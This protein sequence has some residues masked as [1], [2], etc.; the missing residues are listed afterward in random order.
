MGLGAGGKIQQEIYAD[1][2]GVDAW[3]SVVASRLCVHTCNAMMWRAI[4]G[5]NPP[6]PPLTAKEYARY[7]I[8]LFDFYRDDLTALNETKELAAVKSIGE[9]TEEKGLGGEHPDEEIDPS[10]IIQYG[11]T[12]RPEEIQPWGRS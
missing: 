6:H 3:S 4:T 7:R 11:N 12:R 9:I 2:Y 5:E 8:P 1:Q 10:L